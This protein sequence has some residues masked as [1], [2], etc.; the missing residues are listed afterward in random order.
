MIRERAAEREEQEAK[1][2]RE[3]PRKPFILQ[4][5]QT[6]AA[7]QLTPDEKYV[8]ATIREPAKGRQANHRAQVRDRVGL[9]GRHSVL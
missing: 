8:I 9:H 6:V 7:L 3:H 5:G 4:A 1:R 2:K